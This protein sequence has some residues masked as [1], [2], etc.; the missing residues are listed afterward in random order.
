MQ[1]NTMSE[2]YKGCTCGQ[3]KFDPSSDLS[4]HHPLGKNDYIDAV[5]IMKVPKLARKSP[6]E[7]KEIFRK[8]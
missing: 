3:Y 6:K 5:K 2:A 1:S 4:D 8:A 7:K